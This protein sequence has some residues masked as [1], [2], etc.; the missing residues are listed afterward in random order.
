MLRKDKKIKICTTA[1][2]GPHK[3]VRRATNGPWAELYTPPAAWPLNVEFQP[4]L[5]LTRLSHTSD[6]ATIEEY[7]S[8]FPSY[9]HHV[10]NCMLIEIVMFS[11]TFPP[12][13]ICFSQLPA[14]IQDS[15]RKRLTSDPSAIFTSSFLPPTPPHPPR[16]FPSLPRSLSMASQREWECNYAVRRCLQTQKR[17]NLFQQL[18]VISQFNL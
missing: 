15:V 1:D 6:D 17:L 18:A 11:V 10:F 12:R 3:I 7:L 8:V 9:R 16:C 14:H 13:L 5:T 4:R 2:R